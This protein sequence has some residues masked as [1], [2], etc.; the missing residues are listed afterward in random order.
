MR[1]QTK[2]I[3]ICG[4]L[5]ALAVSVLFLGTIIEVFDLS[6]AVI[7][8]I[9]VYIVVNTYGLSSGFA[10]YAV[11]SILSFLLLT[12]KFTPIAFLPIGIYPVIKKFFDYRTK[13]KVLR[14]IFKL[15]VF[16]VFFTLLVCLGKSFLFTI[17][18]NG[19]ISFWEKILIYPIGNCFAVVFDVFLNRIGVAYGPI[20]RRILLSIS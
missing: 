11:I 9:A 8:A 5:S 6:A 7:A 16:N 17:D 10:V 20:M 4:V 12:G 19:N 18:D 2:K 13:Q 3:A 1:G 14:I 15:L